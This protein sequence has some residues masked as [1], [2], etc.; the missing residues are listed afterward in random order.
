[1]EVFLERYKFFWYIVGG[2]I[3]FVVWCRERFTV[4]FEKNHGGVFC[5]YGFFGGVN[6][7]LSLENWNALRKTD[8]SLGLR[9]DIFIFCWMVCIGVFAANSNTLHIFAML[10]CCCMVQRKVHR[11][12]S[13]KPWWCL[14]FVWFYRWRKCATIF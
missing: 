2:V 1:M 11:V 10:I 14:L 6:V 13:E 7:P 4:S 8:W 3:A 12:F 9:F 5:L